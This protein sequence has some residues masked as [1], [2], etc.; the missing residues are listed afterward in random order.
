[1]NTSLLLT[2]CLSWMSSEVPRHYWLVTWTDSYILCTVKSVCIHSSGRWLNIEKKAKLQPVTWFLYCCVKLRGSWLFGSVVVNFS[3][4]IIRSISLICALEIT[5]CGAGGGGVER[6][7][8]G[9]YWQL[10]E[11][12]FFILLFFI[13][14]H[15]QFKLQVQSDTN[16]D[17]ILS[18]VWL[19]DSSELWFVGDGK[20][21]QHG[22]PAK[23]YFCWDIWSLFWNR[24]AVCNPSRIPPEQSSAACTTPHPPI[25]HSNPV[26]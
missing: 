3:Y 20:A 25:S 9:Q 18:S 17:I 26:W 6:G 5:R 24:P 13:Y 19:I 16:K 14:L 23:Q 11:N 7:F 15:L 22:S 8:R 10:S 12:F 1:M 4:H 2:I 21:E